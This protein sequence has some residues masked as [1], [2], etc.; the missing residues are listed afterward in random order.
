MH[1]SFTA[2]NIVATV[3]SIIYKF[4][5]PYLVYVSVGRYTLLALGTYQYNCSGIGYGNVT[6]VPAKHSIALCK[7]CIKGSQEHSINVGD[8]VEWSVA[9]NSEMQGQS[10]NCTMLIN[11]VLGGNKS[12]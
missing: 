6:A 12:M 1:E 10:P 2:Y 5:L 4:M 7:Q 8:L 11:Q 9:S 3:W